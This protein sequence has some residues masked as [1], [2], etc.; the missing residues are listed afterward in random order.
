MWEPRRLPT[1]WA[2]TGI[3]LLYY[4]MLYRSTKGRGKKERE[5][6]KEEEETYT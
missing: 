6:E 2:S 1:R 3:A 4:F 5:G